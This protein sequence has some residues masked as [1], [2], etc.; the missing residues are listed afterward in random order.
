MELR[1]GEK[2]LRLGE[3]ELRLGEIDLRWGLFSNTQSHYHTYPNAYR[4]GEHESL[5]S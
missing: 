5:G 2:E 1:L 4:E 3:I